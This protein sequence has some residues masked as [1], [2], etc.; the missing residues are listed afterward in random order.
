MTSPARLREQALALPASRR[1]I[2]ALEI[3]S[4][5]AAD[6]ATPE[7]IERAWIAEA[8]R[9]AEEMRDDDSLDIPAEE[10]IAELRAIVSGDAEPDTA[11]EESFSLLCLTIVDRAAEERESL[12]RAVMSSLDDGIRGLSDDE[13]TALR[14][15]EVERHLLALRDGRG[16]EAPP[17]GPFTRVWDL[18]GVPA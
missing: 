4:S 11:P 6:L 7:E 17:V 8:A 5:L 12:L 15:K 13:F 18:A 10:V 16:R 1:A 14:R 3:I 9:R 2:L